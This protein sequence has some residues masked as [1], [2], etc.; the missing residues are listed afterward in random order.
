MWWF[1]TI[2]TVIQYI[3]MW[4]HIKED[5]DGAASISFTV[6]IWGT[7]LIITNWS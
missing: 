3:G 7:Y 2:M 6:A 5:E 4:R 1:I